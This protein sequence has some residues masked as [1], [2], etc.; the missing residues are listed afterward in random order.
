MPTIRWDA[1][2][3]NGDVGR[4]AAARDTICVDVWPAFTVRCCL[5]VQQ[6]AKEFSN[7]GMQMRAGHSDEWSPGT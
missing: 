5:S 1:G 3:V 2:A 6:E 4:H 7:G